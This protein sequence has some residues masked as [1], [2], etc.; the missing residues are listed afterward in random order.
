VVHSDTLKWAARPLAF[1]SAVLIAV[2]ALVNERR[3]RPRRC[4]DGSAPAPR[5]KRICRPA[6]GEAHWP[7]ARAEDAVGVET[8]RAHLELRED[9]LGATRDLLRLRRGDFVRAEAGDA[10]RSAAYT[11]KRDAT[12]SSWRPPWVPPLR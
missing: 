6:L 12:S 1:L 2:L 10:R 11:R 8:V 9:L 4:D 5:R 7:L 3:S